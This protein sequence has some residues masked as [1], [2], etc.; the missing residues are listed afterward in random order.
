MMFAVSSFVY[1]ELLCCDSFFFFLVLYL[2]GVGAEK[3]TASV[4]PRWSKTRATTP[5]PVIPLPCA[6]VSLAPTS[7]KSTK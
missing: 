5:A 7:T 6:G 1:S 3:L 4:P 2:I